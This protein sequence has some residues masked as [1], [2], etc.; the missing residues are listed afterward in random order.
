MLDSLVRVSR[1]VVWNHFANILSAGVKDRLGSLFIHTVSKLSGQIRQEATG[2]PNNAADL[3]LIQSMTNGY[4]TQAETQ[5]TFHWLFTP[6]QTDDGS[7]TGKCTPRDPLRER[8][9]DYL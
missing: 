2:F 5:D 7:F 1:R 6:S 9:V 3:S 8:D 4:N